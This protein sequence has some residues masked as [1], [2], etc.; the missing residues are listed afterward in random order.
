MI[1]N[2]SIF[3]YFEYAPDKDSKNNKPLN[4]EK[5]I[6]PSFNKSKEK[7]NSN[8]CQSKIDTNHSFLEKKRKETN[9]RESK[10]LIFN[11]K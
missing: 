8:N 9:N 4:T 3:D 6:L 7:E 2:K 11:I 5:N 10:I 1:Q